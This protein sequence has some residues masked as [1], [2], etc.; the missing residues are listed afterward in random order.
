MECFSSQGLYEP[1]QHFKTEEKKPKK[2]Q[3]TSSAKP[4]RS[5]KMNKTNNFMNMTMAQMVSNKE[6][7]PL[8]PKN[9]K[10]RSRLPDQNMFK[11]P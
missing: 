7:D 1:K 2:M 6:L 11:T 9:N 8:I 5:K 10:T 4:W 3:R